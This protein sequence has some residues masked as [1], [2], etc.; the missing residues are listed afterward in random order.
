MPVSRSF[1]I[2]HSA[3]LIF[4][5]IVAAVFTF[6]QTDLLF[7]H[8]DTEIFLFSRDTNLPDIL[9]P[10]LAVCAAVV[11][12]SMIL[13]RKETFP[14]QITEPK[15]ITTFI[16]AFCGLTFLVLFGYNIYKL[17][18]D[19][20]SFFPDVPSA[21]KL[22]SSILAFPS[23]MYFLIIA[24]KRNPYK[25]PTAMFGLCVVIWGI[26]NLMGEYFTMNSPLNDPV[27]VIHQLSYIAIMLF[28]LY[29]AGYSAEIYKP[30][31]YQMF[32][33]LSI[34]FISF[35][36]IPAIILNLFNLK[37]L[38]IDMMSCYVEFCLLLFIICRMVNINIK[39]QP[40]NDVIREDTDI[41]E[42]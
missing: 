17:V 5:L 41:N 37:P 11:A 7:L 3:Y 20:G 13:L 16:S 32:G 25:K 38:S 29:D 33:Y 39:K 19:T 40:Q 30:V 12:T 8:Y 6:I 31:L 10:A 24:L 23:G 35:S 42:K 1:Y 14:E 21:L 9:Y 34:I 18:I 4:S 28:Y 27:R 26:L 22:G 36:S 2:K 15:N